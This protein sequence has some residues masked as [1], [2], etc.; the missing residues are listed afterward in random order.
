MLSSDHLMSGNGP[1]YY[2]QILN[3]GFH[4]SGT[5]YS[6]NTGFTYRASPV[7]RTVRCCRGL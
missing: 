1:H 5:F 4:W 6:G 7:E 2:A 3:E